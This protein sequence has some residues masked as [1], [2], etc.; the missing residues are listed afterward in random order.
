MIG[1]PTPGEKV[2]FCAAQGHRVPVPGRP[3]SYYKPGEPVTE[4]WSY[5]HHARYMAGALVL[6]E[7]AGKPAGAAAAPTEEGA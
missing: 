1:L 5:Q 2:T 7:W 6:I 4:V 3:G